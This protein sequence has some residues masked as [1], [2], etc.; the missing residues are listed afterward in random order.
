[1]QPLICCLGT[2][3]RS[4]SPEHF[5]CLS[6][7]CLKFFVYLQIAAACVRD[8]G[9]VYVYGTTIS[10]DVVI[11]ASDLRRKVNVTFWSLTHF[12]SNKSKKQK[13]LEDVTKLIEKKIISPLVGEKFNL[14]DVKEAINQSQRSGRGGKVLL[15][16]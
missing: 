9:D 1:M 13:L 2:Q 15:L 14:T 3:P 12:L 10:P 16:H 6:C 7:W 5:A 8:F 11:S 4:L